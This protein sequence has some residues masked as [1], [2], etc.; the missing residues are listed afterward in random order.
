MSN[1]ANSSGSSG[2]SGCGTLIFMLIIVVIFFRGCFGDSSDDSGSP[3]GNAVQ[4]E[5]QDGYGK[6]PDEFFTGS[7][8]VAISIYYGPKLFTDEP[9]LSVVLNNCVLGEITE[10]QEK[11][12]MVNLN[13]G[14]KYTLGI[15]KDDDIFGFAIDEAEFKVTANEYYFEYE[16]RDGELN[17]TKTVHIKN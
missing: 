11:K 12:F 1:G 13:E 10:G 7:T 9:K 2:G 16:I 5:S 6:D 15:V 8:S 14:E 17:D 4:T 3:S